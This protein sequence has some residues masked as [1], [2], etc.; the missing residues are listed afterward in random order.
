MSCTIFT[1]YVTLLYCLSLAT[2][3]K[4]ITDCIE[5]LFEYQISVQKKLMYVFVVKLQGITNCYSY[6]NVLE[7]YFSSEKITI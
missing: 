5:F 3:I 7:H 2:L 1:L 4:N 6:I